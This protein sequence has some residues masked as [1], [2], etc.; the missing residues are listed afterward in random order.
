MT[1]NISI[2][3][4]TTAARFLHAP[5]FVQATVGHNCRLAPLHHLPV[6]KTESW[7]T[8]RKGND[9]RTVVKPAQGDPPADA[10]NN[11]VKACT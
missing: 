4:R 9:N 1:R 7:Q 6:I 2:I 3:K 8:P 11:A 5:A 10:V